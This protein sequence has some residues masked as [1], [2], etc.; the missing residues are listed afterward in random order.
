MT[1]HIP[2]TLTLSNLACGCIGIV[3]AF[4][5]ELMWAAALIWVGAVFDFFDGF[6]ARMLKKP[7]ALGLQLDSLADMVTFGVLPA[8]IVYQLIAQV[9]A[10]ELLPYA[11]YVIA[12]FSALRLAKFNID[13][14]QTDSFIGL[15]TPACA[16]FVS[17]LP[18]I[19]HSHG[20]VAIMFFSP[21]LLAALALALALLLV[22]EI[23]MF[24][25]K[26]KS[27]A[28]QANK[29]RYTFLILSVVLIITLGFLSIPLVIVLYVSLSLFRNLTSSTHSGS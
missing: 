13:E 3:Q 8:T 1:R 15:P 27:F 6:A 7:S 22:S 2:N 19:Q 25:L 28:W 11:A 21:W 12:L 5:G 17:A 29:L 23:H 14:R 10:Y 16:L 24:S 20:N 4:Q 9:S 26:F 18:F